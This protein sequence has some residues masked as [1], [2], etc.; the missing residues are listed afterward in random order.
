[1]GQRHRYDQYGP[2]LRPQGFANFGP[3]AGFGGDP[4]NEDLLEAML[5]A[6]MEQSQRRRPKPAEPEDVWDGM[7]GLGLV[8]GAIVASWALSWA[9]SPF[10]S[11]ISSWARWQW[12]FLLHD[13]TRA[14]G[15]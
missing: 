12:R 13:I 7:L 1:M 15:R 10:F 6:M 8:A 11:R 2:S 9:F 4:F 3:E 5:R 14:L